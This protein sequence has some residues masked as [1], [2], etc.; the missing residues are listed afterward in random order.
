M[1]AT[2]TDVT[3][4]LG[5]GGDVNKDRVTTFTR[6]YRVTLSAASAYGQDLAIT[7]TNIP[8]VGSYWPRTVSGR[9]T[10]TVR[11]VSARPLDAASRKLWEV[12]VSYSNETDS[13]GEKESEAEL[14]PWLKTPKYNYDFNDYA[15]ALEYDNGS[16]TG[17]KVQNTLGE[18]FDPV[19]TVSKALRRITIT[20]ASVSYND[21]TA[22][23]I[24]NTINNA[25]ITIRGNTY[26]AGML[27]LLKWSAVSN[28]YAT[29]QGVLIDYFDE[30]V[31][32]EVG[33]YTYGHDL[34]ILNQGYKE[35]KDGTV[36]RAVDEE[37]NFEAQPVPLAADGTRL[38]VDATPVFQAFQP[39]RSADWSALLVGRL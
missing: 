22:D 18:P 25:P 9:A 30:T 29:D 12:T 8:T 1:S 35:L 38:A 7:A 36:Q 21:A 13:A 23:A 15:V 39:Y 10:P 20:R 32:V 24:T 27:R 37:G 6:R 14:A 3:E 31:E 11:N 16:P 17:R 4:M 5:E 26:A 2:V 34:R 28:E 33:D 19:P